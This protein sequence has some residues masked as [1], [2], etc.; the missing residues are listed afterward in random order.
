MFFTLKE[1]ASR[2]N[3]DRP[4]ALPSRRFCLRLS[5][6]VAFAFTYV[7]HANL[8]AAEAEGA[9]GEVFNV[10]CGARMTLNEMLD[11]L[12]T[13]TGNDVEVEYAPPRPGDVMHS[14]ADISKARRVLGYEPKVT[15]AEGLNRSVG[16]YRGIVAHAT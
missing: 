1:S 5:S 13:F 9:A 11:Q 15:A 16:W 2:S 3:S 8:L 14:L 10:A 6:F 4:T 12:R 7:V